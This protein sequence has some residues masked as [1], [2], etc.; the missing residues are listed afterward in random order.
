M[1][2][3]L[4]GYVARD[5]RLFDVGK[6]TKTP[7]QCALHPGLVLRFGGRLSYKVLRS[8]RTRQLSDVP[9]LIE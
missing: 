1:T 4:A 8:P 2:K 7:E 6:K 9:T 5:P 3:N